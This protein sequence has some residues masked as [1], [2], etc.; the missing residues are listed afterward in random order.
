LQRSS[1]FDISP[2]YFGATLQQHP[3]QP[4]IVV[5]SS[6]YQ[7]CVTVPI[8][9]AVLF[10]AAEPRLGCLNVPGSNSL[11]QIPTGL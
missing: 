7:R 5:S 9:S 8:I 3:R 6:I 11:N 4:L 2:I 1:P 10:D